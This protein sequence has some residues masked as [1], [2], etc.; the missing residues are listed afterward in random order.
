[1]NRE[2]LIALRDAVK[3]ERLTVAM[4]EDAWPERHEHSDD[5]PAYHALEAYHGSL[6]AA[7]ALHEAVLPGWAAVCDTTGLATV[8]FAG[9]EGDAPYHDG[10]SVNNPARAWLLAILEALI[11]ETPE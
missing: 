4:C 10:E 11:A 5:D 6:D 9:V 2:A 3:A 8:W 7:L 1:M